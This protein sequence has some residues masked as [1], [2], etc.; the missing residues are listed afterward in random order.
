VGDVREVAGFWEAVALCVGER[1]CEA[2]EYGLEQGWAGRSSGQQRGC[3]RVCERC[4]LD[5]V[6][7][8]IGVLVGE[9]RRVPD[10]PL[11]LLWGEQTPGAGAE[12]DVLDEALGRFGWCGPAGSVRAAQWAP[13]ADPRERL[14]RALA[15]IYGYY[16]R[17]EALLTNVTRDAEPM[18]AVRAAGT[19]RR[20]WLADVEQGPA[21]GWDGNAQQMRH[22]VALSSSMRGGTPARGHS[23]AVRQARSGRLGGEF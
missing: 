18:P 20:Q 9:G 3:G 6:H 19:Y 17:N 15:A 22:A 21:Q 1:R 16:E 23:T 5:F 12:G 2:L 7:G 10:E 4:E 8:G 14:R 13:L 11:T